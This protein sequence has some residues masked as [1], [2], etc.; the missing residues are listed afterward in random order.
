MIRRENLKGKKDIITVI[1]SQI[2]LP[3]DQNNGGGGGRQKNKLNYIL[4]RNLEDTE[5]Y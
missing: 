5:S 2:P 4:I 1:N 3:P